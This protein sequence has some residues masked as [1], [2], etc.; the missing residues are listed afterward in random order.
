MS[1][2]KIKRLAAKLKQA[3]RLTDIHP[4]RPAPQPPQPP[5][6]APG[7]ILF[8]SDGLGKPDDTAPRNQA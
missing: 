8:G 1:H 2:Q 7:N 4:K 5:R 6:S 3:E